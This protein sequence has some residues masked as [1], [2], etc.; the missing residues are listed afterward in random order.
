MEREPTVVEVFS[1]MRYKELWGNL[2]VHVFILIPASF[3]LAFLARKLDHDWGWDPLVGQPWNLV[4]CAICWVVGAYV[5][6]YSY[7]YLF[8]K[9]MG[10]PGG[11][12]GYTTVLVETGV[13]SWVR[14]PSVIGKLIGVIGLGFLMRSPAFLMVFIPLLFLYSYITNRRIQ[15]RVCLRSFGEEYERYRREVPMFIPRWRRVKRFI[16]ERRSP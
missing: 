15:E 16:E 14:H 2:A 7:G 1:T 12:M 8:I 3:L 13:Y 10:S 9:G 11:H 5:I 6:W 4:I